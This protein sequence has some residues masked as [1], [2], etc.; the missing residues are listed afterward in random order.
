[1]A[2]TPGLIGIFQKISYAKMTF[3]TKAFIIGKPLNIDIINFNTLD[4]NFITI[5]GANFKLLSIIG[6]EK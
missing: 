6:A 1:M 2:L 4:R 3:F 5:L